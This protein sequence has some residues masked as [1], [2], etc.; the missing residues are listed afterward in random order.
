MS[1]E[2]VNGQVLVVCTGNVCRSPYMERRLRQGLDGYGV[3][4]VSAG[5]NALVGAGIDPGSAALLKDAGVSVCGHEARQLTREMVSSTDLIL[6]AAREHRAEVVQY[7]PKALAYTF[8]WGDF[9]D[10]V[11]GLDTRRLAESSVGLSW[12]SRVA[13][14][15]AA[16][17]GVVLPRAKSQTDILDPYRQDSVAFTRMAR[18]VEVGLSDI[19]AA[20]TPRSQD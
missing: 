18:R 3:E 16:R 19:V 20:L 8:T 6:V 14:E 17:R 13:A 7:F 1:Q 10:L 5:T 11:A 2:G 12:V 15:A 9:A 4:V